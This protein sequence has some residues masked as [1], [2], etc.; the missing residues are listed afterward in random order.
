MVKAVLDLIYK[1][2]AIRCVADMQNQT[3]QANHALSHDR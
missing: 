1:D 3:R 2:N